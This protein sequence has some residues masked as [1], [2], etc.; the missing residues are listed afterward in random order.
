MGIAR[1]RRIDRGWRALYGD[2]TMTRLGLGSA[3]VLSAV[4]VS[5]CPSDDGGG[6]STVGG[7]GSSGGGTTEAGTTASTGGGTDAGSGDAT[8]GSSTSSAG[9]GTADGTSTAGDD[10]PPPEGSSGS[11]TGGS[12]PGEGEI[13]GPCAGGMCMD[14]EAYCFVAGDGQ[15]MCL[16]SCDGTSPSCPAAPP[17]NG[18]L[19]ECIEVPSGAAP[20]CM[21]NCMD[22]AACPEG[23]TCI[24]L[25]GIFRCL[26]P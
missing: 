7:S 21:L 2:L 23:T 3:L 15:T 25:G 24:D 8:A 6:G 20:H 18:S 9:T 13:Y 14:A 16:P 4:L 19:V 5:G 11:E 26:W 1:L 10:P 12:S 17:D 22:G